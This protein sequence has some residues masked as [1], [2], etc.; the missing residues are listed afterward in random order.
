MGRDCKW[1]NFYHWAASIGAAMMKVRPFERSALW[2]SA[3]VKK[4]G[5]P[6]ER[7]R[8]ALAEAYRQLRERAG[9]L[10]GEIHAVL[11]QLTVHDLT[12][13]DA[14]WDVASEICGPNYRLNPLQAFVLGASFL[15]HD[16]GM[17]LAAYPGGL[18]ELKATAQYRDA[19]VAAWKKR[20][21]DEPLG[22]QR[23]NPPDDICDEATFQVLRAR[24]ASQAKVLATALWT[25]PETGRPM[26]LVQNDDLLE[27]YGELIGNISASHHWPITELARFFGD[28]TPASAAWPRD[29]EVDG[30]VLACILRCA[31]ACAID[32]TRAPSFL[33]ALRKPQG[34]SKRHW[35]FQNKLYPGKRRDDAL[36]FES[37]SGFDDRQSEDWW[38]CFDAIGIADKELRGADAL[39]SDRK[40]LPF[41]TRRVAG[42]NDAD[43]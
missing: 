28:A 12:H 7:D 30:L 11:P 22:D 38:L 2:R 10:V 8:E 42:A 24:H 37:K 27:S 5:D 40:R 41:L 17:A 29:W 18:S 32:E 21:I 16:A 6:D 9:A 34:V 31:D 19:I 35:T 20:G 25:H 13:A 43:I 1:L 26:A 39:L 3:F 4:K 36:V 14:L 23:E 15:L 33:F